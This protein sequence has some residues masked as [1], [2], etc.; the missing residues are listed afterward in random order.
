M[1]KLLKYIITAIVDHPEDVKIEEEETEEQ[2]LIKISV[3][4]E[5]AGKV[6]GKG[7]KIIK[8]IRRLAYILATKR[9]KRLNIELVET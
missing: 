7:G 3:H 6:I 9:K 2:L 1:K 8:A 4:P 5:D